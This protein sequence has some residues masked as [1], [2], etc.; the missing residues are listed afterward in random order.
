MILLGG[1]KEDNMF[2]WAGA[3]RSPCLVQKRALDKGY[4][5]WN[6]QFALTDRLTEGGNGNYFCIEKERV[7]LVHPAELMNGKRSQTNRAVGG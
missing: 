1:P 7:G 5:V 6:S 4:E 2:E 3:H